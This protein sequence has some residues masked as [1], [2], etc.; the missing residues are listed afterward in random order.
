MHHRHISAISQ[1]NDERLERLRLP[2]I[3][4]LIGRHVSSIAV[5]R[6]ITEPPFDFAAVAGVARQGGD[7]GI[8]DS[9]LF[10]EDHYGF[11]FQ[12]V[13]S[14]GTSGGGVGRAHHA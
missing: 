14:G 1:M 11:G 8:M 3:A 5:R 13:I 9:T 7:S 4:K 12:H 6:K 10:K 2:Y